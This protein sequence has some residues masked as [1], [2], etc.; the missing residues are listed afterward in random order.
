MS[1]TFLE[2]LVAKGKQ[3]MILEILQDK[4]IKIPARIEIAIHEISDSLDDCRYNSGLNCYLSVFI[5]RFV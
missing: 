5:R 4:F 1:L 2:K 3:D